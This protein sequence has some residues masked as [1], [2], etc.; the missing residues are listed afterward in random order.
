MF[1]WHLTVEKD[2]FGNNMQTTKPALS[3]LQTR[4]IFLLCILTFGIAAIADGQDMCRDTLHYHFYIGYAYLHNR[5][6][7]DVMAAGDQNYLNPFFD[8]LN[9]WVMTTLKPDISIFLQGAITGASCFVILLIAEMLFTEETRKLRLFYLVFVLWVGATGAANLTVI[10]TFTNDNKMALLAITAVYSIL[11]AMTVTNKTL[12]LRYLVAGGLLIGLDTG[13]KLVA[14]SYAAGILIG[15]FFSRVCNRQ[16]VLHSALLLLMIITGFA[17]ADGYWMALVYNNFQNPIFPYFN[18][19]FHSP[20]TLPARIDKESAAVHDFLFPFYFAFRYSEIPTFADCRLAVIYAGT[21]I[22]ICQRIIRKASLTIRH[23]L[24]RF[25]TIY[26][27]ISYFSWF[28]LFTEY[29]YQLPLEF[30]S[31]IMMVGILKLITHNTR[32]QV[33][34]LTSLVLL[35]GATTNPLNLFKIKSSDTYFQIGIPPLPSN[36]IILVGSH[37]ATYLSPFFPETT[38]FIGLPFFVYMEE[39]AT[40]SKLK[41]G[42]PN[43]LQTTYLDPIP[44]LINHEPIYLLESNVYNIE[45]FLYQNNKPGEFILEKRGNNWNIARVNLLSGGDPISADE[46]EGIKYFLDSLPKNLRPEELSETQIATFH[47]IMEAYAKK[48]PHYDSTYAV[49]ELYYKYG[50]VKD[51]PHCLPIKNNEMKYIQ[52]CPLK[53]A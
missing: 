34:I 14:I 22:L 20:Y 11:K 49:R 32:L 42:F 25:L 44:R 4:W 23:P 2:I 28:Y 3:S 10:G 45:Q 30:I 43:R 40:T 17:I 47:R 50:L 24:W 6:S 37:T 21:V 36:A 31:G 39:R 13:L 16:H 5:F 18:N 38:R 19:I 48:Y 7:W 27:L 35:F 1:I 26:F 15:F 41:K 12:Q 8:V 53:K 9:Y 52:I 46:I 51:T 33:I 29:R